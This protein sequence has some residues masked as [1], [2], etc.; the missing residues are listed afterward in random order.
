MLLM[1]NAPGQKERSLT[2]VEARVDLSDN[3]PRGEY[4]RLEGKRMLAY[5]EHE[6]AVQVVLPRFGC[7]FSQ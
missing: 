4:A 5:V 2:F 6:A 1:S 7:N 3:R